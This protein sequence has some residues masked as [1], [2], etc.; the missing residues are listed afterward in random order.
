MLIAGTGG[1]EVE[2]YYSLTIEFQFCKMNKF[3]RFIDY[4]V[5]IVNTTELYT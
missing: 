3:E 5:N 2:S 1:K 4:D